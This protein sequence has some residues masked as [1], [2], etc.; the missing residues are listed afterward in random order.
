MV[1]VFYRK[2]I[3][4]VKHD[5]VKRSVFDKQQKTKD[6]SVEED[7]IFTSND[8]SIATVDE[9]GKVTPETKKKLNSKY[10]WFYY[11]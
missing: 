6:T 7:Y 4:P 3:L 9:N 5:N 8:P 11:C 10:Y 1:K 2:Y